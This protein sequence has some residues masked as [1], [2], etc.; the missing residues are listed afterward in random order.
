MKCYMEICIT[1]TGAPRI[2]ADSVNYRDCATDG[3]AIH[4]HG[5]IRNPTED[6]SYQENA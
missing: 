3:K 6:A 4:C 2:G 1:F 5:G